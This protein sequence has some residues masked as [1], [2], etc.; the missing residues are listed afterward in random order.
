MMVDNWYVAV[1]KYKEEKT[2]ETFQL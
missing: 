2:K 1:F